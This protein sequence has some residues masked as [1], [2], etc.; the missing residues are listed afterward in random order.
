MTLSHARAVLRAALSVT[1]LFGFTTSCASGPPRGTS[2]TQSVVTTEDLERNPNEPIEDILQ[3][4]V[5]GVLV[6]R[7]ADGSI[8][9]QIRGN[10]S[11]V[12]DD[13]PLYLLDDMP[14]EP[15]PDGA[16]TGVDPYNIVSIR[17]LKGADAAIYGSRGF[18]GVILITTKKA[19][20]GT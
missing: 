14:L 8:S 4:K 20:K 15:G 19:G 16:L 17:V 7:T 1:V 11:F 9:V 6:R 3:A 5:P 12:G 10:H 18:N 2:P 13:A